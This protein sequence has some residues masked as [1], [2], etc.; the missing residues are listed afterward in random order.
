MDLDEDSK[1]RLIKEFQFVI[2]KME[3]C[4]TNL[5]DMLFYYSGLG[6]AV[7]R[8][9]NIKW[10][11]GLMLIHMVLQ[12]SYMEMQAGIKD[13]RYTQTLHIEKFQDCLLEACTDLAHSL[14]GKS[15]SSDTLW[16]ILSRIAELSYVLTG[17][18]Y[19]NFVRGNLPL[20]QYK[21]LFL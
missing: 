6:G 4:K 14:S 12:Y 13:P 15:A 1:T 19:Y 3:E 11:R 7:N 17:N 8:E 5:P 21:Q 10:D 16:Y 9:L 2:G 20:H 18:G